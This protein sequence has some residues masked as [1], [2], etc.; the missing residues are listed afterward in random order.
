MKLS[1]RE[2]AKN[3]SFCFEAGNVLN[4]NQF[5]LKSNY[6]HIFLGLNS[7][8]ALRLRIGGGSAKG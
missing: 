1:R 3:V 2:K 5:A 8:A 4:N 7:C 6:L